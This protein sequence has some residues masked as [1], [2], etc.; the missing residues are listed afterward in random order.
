MWANVTAN[1]ATK[2]IRGRFIEEARKRSVGFCSQ[3]SENEEYK[4]WKREQI[5]WC[6]L[7]VS[8]QN[9]GAAC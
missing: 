7:C 5:H 4:F 9:G 2:I 1:S 8:V 6:F 3:L